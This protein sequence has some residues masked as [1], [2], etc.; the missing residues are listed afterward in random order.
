MPSLGWAEPKSRT[1]KCG[2]KLRVAVKFFSHLITI[3]QFVHKDCDDDEEECQEDQ[4]EAQDDIVLMPPSILLLGDFLDDDTVPVLSFILG[5]SVFQDIKSL[6]QL[7]DIFFKHHCIRNVTRFIRL[8][9]VVEGGLDEKI[10]LELLILLII[11]YRALL[12]S[13]FGLLKQLL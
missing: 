2:S 6:A 9:L 11:T 10:F 12:S 3:L 5:L 8:N 4:E 1:E 13:S 7:T